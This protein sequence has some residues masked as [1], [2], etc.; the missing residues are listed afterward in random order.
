[1]SRQFTRPSKPAHGPG[2]FDRRLLADAHKPTD[3]ALIANAIREL[4][5]TG[6]TAKDISDTLRIGLAAVQ[7][8]L[9]QDAGSHP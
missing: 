1:M 8:A 3:G 9:R 6:L 5:R 7:Q 4:H 2:A